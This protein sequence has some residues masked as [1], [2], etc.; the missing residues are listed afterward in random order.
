ME[1]QEWPDVSRLCEEA[2]WGL[3]SRSEPDPGRPV[4]H[5]QVQLLPLGN[6]ESRV[7]E[8]QHHATQGIRQ[9][10]GIGKRKD[11]ELS[12]QKHANNSWWELG[13]KAV[14]R[15]RRCWKWKVSRATAWM[16][17][18]QSALWNQ[19]N[20]NGKP[21]CGVS[22]KLATITFILFL[23]SVK[24]LL[25]AEGWGVGVGGSVCFVYYN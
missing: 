21:V 24:K 14:G 5:D 3:K 4:C 16:W 18:C 23:L 1:N 13:R 25:S 19:S 15:H 11:R 17:G 6:K 12:V 10:E 7:F 2:S 20:Q 8:R 9:C 22:T